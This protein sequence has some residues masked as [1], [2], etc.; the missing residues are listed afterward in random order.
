M[1]DKIIDKILKSAVKNQICLGCQHFNLTNDS[2]PSIQSQDNI[3]GFCSAY[4]ITNPMNISS[5]LEIKP[6]CK[7]KSFNPILKI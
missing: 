6:Y 5:S 1:R 2:K 3:Y 7:G 4:K